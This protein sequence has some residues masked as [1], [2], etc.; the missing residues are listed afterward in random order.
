MVACLD[1]TMW[2]RPPEHPGGASALVRATF[3]PGIGTAET[4]A[5][6]VQHL[7]EGSGSLP[8]IYLGVTSSEMGNADGLVAL[9]DDSLP[10]RISGSLSCYEPSRSPLQPS[11]RNRGAEADDRPDNGNGA[12]PPNVTSEMPVGTLD[13]QRCQSRKS[14]GL[15]RAAHCG[16]GGVMAKIVDR[17]VVFTQENHTTDNYFTSM[18]AWGANVAT[19]WP[20]QP[21]PPAHDQ[22]HTRAAYAKWLHAQANGTLTSAA[23]T[24]STPTR[25]CRTT[26]GWPRPQRSW[27]TTAPGSA[28]T[29]PRTTC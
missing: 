22:G 26:R 1:G 21:N 29:P 17:V 8:W 10:T 16:H 25:S 5:A 9:A 7:L 20:T 14:V 28:R 6:R 13:K 3:E 27:K 4:L 19:G 23:H 15:L 2:D 24:Q 11:R 18:R 12:Q